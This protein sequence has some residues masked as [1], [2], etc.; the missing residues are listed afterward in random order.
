MKYFLATLVLLSFPLAAMA[1]GPNAGTDDY[2]RSI[3]YTNEQLSAGVATE[4]RESFLIAEGARSVSDPVG[5]VL[6][7]VGDSTTLAEPWGDLTGASLA[8]D[9]TTGTWVFTAT[10]A[11]AIPDKPDQKFNVL[12]YVDIDG[13][14][15]NNETQGV[16]ADTDA[17]YTVRYGQIDEQGTLAWNLGFR[18]YNAAENAQTWATNKDTAGTFEVSGDTVTLRIPFSEMNADVTARWRAATAVTD[19]TTTEIDVAPTVG[20]PPPKGQT[21]PDPRFDPFGTSPSAPMSIPPDA[22]ILYALVGLAAIV[23]GWSLARLRKT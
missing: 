11:D 1:S 15:D 10:V 4:E 3:G 5:D 21:Y 12:F 23:L 13:N 22:Y 8:K 7:R 17:E 14:R 2:L 20:F 16:R 6:D 9:E 18:W 19:G